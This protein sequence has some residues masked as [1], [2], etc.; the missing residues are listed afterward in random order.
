MAEEVGVDYGRAIAARMAPIGVPTRAPLVPRRAARRGRRAHRPRLRRPRRGAR[1]LAPIV[2]RALPV[3]RRRQRAPAVICA[4][5][6]GMVHGM[7]AGL[8]G[9]TA[10]AVRPRADPTATTTASPASDASTLVR[11]AYLDHA[12]TSPLRPA[13]SRRCCRSSASTT[14]TPAASTPRAGSPG[15]GRGRPRAGRRASRRPPREVVFTASATEAI[16]AACWGAVGAGRWRRRTSSPP[17]SSTRPCSTRAARSGAATLTVVGVDRLGPRRRRR[18]RSPRSGPTTALVHCSWPTTRSAR[19]SPWPRSSAACRERGVARPRRRVQAAGHV[20]VDFARA[21]RRPVLGQRPQVRRARRR[22]RPARPPRPAAPAA[23]RRRRAGAGPPGRARERAGHRRLRRR[24]RRAAADGR[25]AAEAHAQRALTDACRRAAPA[26]CRRRRR[27][28]ATPPS[29]C[30]TSCAS[31]SRASRPSRPA[32]ARPAGV[33]V[34]SGSACSS[35]ALEPSPVLEAM[36]VDADHSLR[37]SVGW[38]TPEPTS[39]RSS[40]PSPPSWT[41]CGRCGQADDASI[42]GD[43]VAPA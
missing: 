15:R 31:A 7:L 11:H 6:R 29:A 33:A 24:G 41:A 2:V 30:R 1:R 22:R 38:S 37:V 36:G 34:H 19:S 27:A 9:E 25:L 42:P 17:R 3:R 18:G 32:R 40:T 10:P 5:D 28:T 39:T 12:S 20:P 4:V 13:A 23:A 8:Y 21:R 43:T 26:R 14:P 16:N 35:E